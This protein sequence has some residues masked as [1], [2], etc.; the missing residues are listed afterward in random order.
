MGEHVWQEKDWKAAHTMPLRALIKHV[1]VKYSESK[2][3][4]QTWNMN[5]SFVDQTDPRHSFLFRESETE[6]IVS[7]TGAHLT[8]KAAHNCTVFKNESNYSVQTELADSRCVSLTYVI[9]VFINCS[10]RLWKTEALWCIF[11]AVQIQNSSLFKNQ[12][13]KHTTVKCRGKKISY[14]ITLSSPEGGN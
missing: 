4:L 5:E 8:S 11:E 10:P 9:F 13:R 14:S 7:I 3:W 12:I 6:S 2:H 1:S